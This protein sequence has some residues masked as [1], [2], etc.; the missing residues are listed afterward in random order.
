MKQIL[1]YFLV[2]FSLII[3]LN[4]SPFAFGQQDQSSGDFIDG[5]F[6]EIGRL[7]KDSQKLDTSKTGDL[8]MDTWMGILTSPKEFFSWNTKGD[9]KL[10][11][12][13]SNTLVE[14][15]QS[16][17]GP[18]S[19][20]QFFGFK[21]KDASIEFDVKIIK[22]TTSDELE[23]TVAD[24]GGPAWG[25]PPAIEIPLETFR[26]STI[27]PT[28]HIS[29]NLS[30]SKY[31]LDKQAKDEANDM[32]LVDASIFGT[33]TFRLKG[34]AE[35]PTTIRLDNLKVTYYK[36]EGE[37]K[38]YYKDNQ[39]KIDKFYKDG[40]QEGLEKRYYRNGQLQSEHPYRNGKLDGIQKYY[41]IDGKVWEET[42]Y[43]DGKREGTQRRYRNGVLT[44]ERLYKNDKMV[45]IKIYY[46]TGE[47][48]S[49]ATIRNDKTEGSS[50]EY[51][52]NGQVMEERIYSDSQRVG[53][54]KHYY[55][56]G[57]LKAEIP[58]K[59]D[60]KDGIARIYNEEGNLV[61]EE[62][63]EKDKLIST[64]EK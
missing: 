36:K 31:F 59:K 53:V 30:N 19:I 22:K 49:E 46:K 63:W 51:Y 14:L 42:P 62:V 52:K 23:V 39:P 40:K 24:V 4:L 2:F 48:K 44:E 1:R 3:F 45:E 64:R 55:A 37:V 61:K 15:T 60:R 16:K 20:S 13:G 29:I 56:N 26:L 25:K 34:N 21:N 7:K 9:V 58:Y 47:I 27:Y 35:E 38:R 18:A 32:D 12:D 28:K 17:E 54:T 8:F 10:V 57:Q 33:I 50:K 5:N 6:E 43:R 11:Y 41:A